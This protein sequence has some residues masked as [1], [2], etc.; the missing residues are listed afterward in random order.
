MT[1]RTLAA[2]LW[3][4]LAPL[5]A[6]AA[7]A[8]ATAK[9]DPVAV[10]QGDATLAPPDPE[11]EQVIEES[12]AMNRDTLAVIST[13]ELSASIVPLTRE[14]LADLA[15]EALESARLRTVEVVEHRKTNP[16]TAGAA[17]E[18]QAAYEDFDRESLRLV[19]LRGAAFD[20]LNLILD[21]WEE[22]GGDA[23]KIAEF[24]AYRRAV[25]TDTVSGLTI[26]GFWQGARRWAA[27]PDGGG[28]LL[29]GV[30]IFLVSI[31]VLLYV[32]K[33]IRAGVSR[34]L[35]HTHT[36]SH[37]L[38]TFI[39]LLVYWVIVLLGLA[40]II[41]AFGFDITPVFA[42]L[43]GA[44]FVL[45]FAMQETLGNFTAGMMILVYR[46]FDQGDRIVTAG[47]EGR[48]RKVNL[49]STI[50][51]T[52]DNQLVTVPN[53]KV[54]NEVIFNT[55]DLGKRRIDLEFRIYHPHQALA[56][57]DGLA[58]LLP[59]IEGVEKQPTPGV[60]FGGFDGRG[61]KLQVRPWT[62]SKA[63]WPTRRAVTR[64][65]MEYLTAQR[66]EL[67]APNLDAD[68]DLEGE[69]PTS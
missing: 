35:T 12:A 8:A 45:A 55:V 49:T 65:V 56:A 63:Y 64:A 51:V 17:T 34:S 67:W 30:I 13:D 44:S 9:P 36:T 7:Q 60:Y 37:L 1:W 50:L 47:V 58:E 40:L 23:D 5:P 33:L 14:E 48:V 6:S 20:R 29:K 28:R 2:A 52:P 27:S 25:I 42:V 31:V 24:R 43:G 3:L 66:I 22:K 41:A 26:G 38:Q 62:R 69:G 57:A 21:E 59:T 4:I 15:E 19:T 68:F 39:G 10:V 46:P 18:S 54:W 53:S 61:A 11:A 32:A 16:R